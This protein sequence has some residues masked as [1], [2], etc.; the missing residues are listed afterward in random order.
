MHREKV[1]SGKE[2]SV[3]SLRKWCKILSTAQ[4]LKQILPIP[5]T[6]IDLPIFLIEFHSHDLGKAEREK[7]M[8]MHRVD[9]ITHTAA[10]V[11]SPPQKSRL[12]CENFFVPLFSHSVSYRSGCTSSYGR[13]DLHQPPAQLHSCFWIF[14]ITFSSYTFHVA[15][16]LLR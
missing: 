12:F 7:I 3:K 16:T 5:K 13:P 1:H 11:V 6:E 9:S 10:R 8:S 15:R 4:K 2:I 14:L